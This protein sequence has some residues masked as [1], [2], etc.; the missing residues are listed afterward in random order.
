MYQK[1]SRFFPEYNILFPQYVKSVGRF[2]VFTGNTNTV[3]ANSS[4]V[5]IHYA[6]AIAPGV[7]LGGMGRRPHVEPASD[8][9]YGENVKI[10]WLADLAFGLSNSSFVYSVRSS[11]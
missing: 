4:S 3:S 5:N 7:L 10:V 2:H 8:D 6:H 11:A 1:A 9:D